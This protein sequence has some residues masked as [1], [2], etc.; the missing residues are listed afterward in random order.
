MPDAD[1]D[2]Y[3]RSEATLA[4][5]IGQLRL[6]RDAQQP[7][8]Q[9]ALLYQR[10]INDV[11]A[12]LLCAERRAPKLREL[13]KAIAVAAYDV[14]IA[15]ADRDTATPGRMAAA[16]MAVV[17][18]VTCLVMAV[19]SWGV[20]GVVFGV[21]L[22][23]AGSLGRWHLRR[24]R[25]VAATDLDAALSRLHNAQDA[26]RLLLASP[27]GD[28]PRSSVPGTIERDTPGVFADVVRLAGGA[29]R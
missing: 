2:E 5:A 20:P 27:H 7:G 9:N 22:T 26:K 18:G 10:R 14:S 15:E 6:L 25:R 4:T 16:T 24:V 13:D 29:A 28:E 12:A 19:M 1:P 11:T 17:A 3:T 8:S 21:I 23:A